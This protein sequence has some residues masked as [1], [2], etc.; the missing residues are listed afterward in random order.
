MP[1][2]NRKTGNVYYEG[3]D[4][5]GLHCP[6]CS[7]RHFK[8]VYTRHIEQGRIERRRECRNCHYR[9]TTWETIAI[10]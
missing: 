3:Q 6:R 2:H 4:D 10:D 8:V 5:R 1:L 9:V 7:C